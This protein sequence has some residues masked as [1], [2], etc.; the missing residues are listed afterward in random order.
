MSLA[1][2]S[3]RIG[4]TTTSTS[5]RAMSRAIPRRILARVTLSS[6]EPPLTP[7]Q[8]STKCIRSFSSSLRTA[9]ENDNV[10]PPSPPASSPNFLSQSESAAPTLPERRRSPSLSKAARTSDGGMNKLLTMFDATIRQN[11]D[12]R[13]QK[14]AAIFKADYKDGISL[15]TPKFEEK[16]EPHHFHIYATRH[17]THITLTDP[18]RNPIISLSCGNI[19]F[20]HSARKHYDS[21]YQLASHVMDR[22]EDRGINSQIKELEVILRGFGA[23]REAVTK[24]LLGLEGRQLRHKVVK[25]ADAT[26]LKFGG[27]RSKKPRRL[28]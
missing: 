28:G 17:N 9:A 22:M 5:I 16:P 20:R 2:R 13:A 18:K 14:D 23:G 15:H 12:T 8:W 11:T 21:A 6:V 1:F 26:R 7:S 10:N 24:A 19:G 4:I 27:T 25:V 3:V